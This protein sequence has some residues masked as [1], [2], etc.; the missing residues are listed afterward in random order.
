MSMVEEDVSREDCNK[1]SFLLAEKARLQ[2][3][4]QQAEEGIRILEPKV[5]R[6]LLATARSSMSAIPFVLHLH[7]T[8]E[9]RAASD[10]QTHLDVIEM[11][12]SAG[13]HGCVRH[14]P[15]YQRLTE[16]AQ[17]LDKKGRHLLEVYPSLNGYVTIETVF[18]ITLNK[19]S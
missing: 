5:A 4:L 6:R 7:D 2:Q 16:I 13:L 19:R 11:L 9:A 12:W 10:R 17:N 8:V 18:H 1:L 15:D 14:E 3:L